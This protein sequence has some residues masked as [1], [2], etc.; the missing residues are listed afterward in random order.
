[1]VEI[2][3]VTQ[4][5]SVHMD[6]FLVTPVRPAQRNAQSRVTVMDRAMPMEH[7]RIVTKNIMPAHVLSVC[8]RFVYIS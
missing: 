1:M 5:V 7:V 3:R 8:I 6:V 4:L 2:R